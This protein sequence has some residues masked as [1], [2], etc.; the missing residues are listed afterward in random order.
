[1]G[2][3]GADPFDLLLY[4]QGQVGAP[5]DAAGATGADNLDTAQRAVVIGEPVPIVFG[6][7][8]GDVGGVLISPGATEARFEND[9]S[10]AVTATY[11][12]LL[13]EGEIDKVQVRDVFQRSCRVGTF[14]Q[15][16]DG[17][18][19][20]WTPG[21]FIVERIGYDKPE[22]PYYCGT[23]GSYAGV[24]TAFFTITVPDGFTQW[25]RQVHMFV[26]GGM[27][28]TRLLDD[29]TG[30]SNNVVDLVRWL[31]TNT[32]RL[33]SRLIDTDGMTAAAEFTDGMGLWFNGELREAQNLEDMMA[34][35]LRYFLLQ[36]TK[37]QGR[38]SLRPLLPVDGDNA[39]DLGP[40][41][42]VYLF[43]E[44][45]I[46][47]GSFEIS[48]IPLADR[49]PICAVMVWRQQPDDDIGLIR[50]T[51]V[52]YTATALEGPFEQH[53]LSQF[54]CSELHAVRAG[55]YILARRRWVTHTLRIR[56][57]PS[58]FNTTLQRGDVVQVK[59][60]RVASSAV[61]GEHNQLYEVD[62]IGKARSGE[63]S[64]DLVHFPVDGD[65]ASLVARDVM[66]ATASGVLFATGKADAITC[67]VNDPD[68]DSVPDEP[69]SPDYEA[70]DGLEGG[71]TGWGD[72]EAPAIPGDPGVP[73]GPPTTP[74][75][76]P[77]GDGIGGG[78]I[79][80]GEESPGGGTENPLDSKDK[81]KPIDLSG[82]PQDLQVGESLPQPLLDALKDKIANS[83]SGEEVGFD[84]S[85]W[86][87]QEY[88]VTFAFGT[89]F[90]SNSSGATGRDELLTYSR[91]RVTANS[92]FRA[93]Y[94]TPSVVFGATVGF[95]KRNGTGGL[96]PETL[97]VTGGIWATRGPGATDFSG[98]SDDV[99]IESATRTA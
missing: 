64:L 13:S 72:T 37:V 30:P 46:V 24:S 4:Q 7:R 45:R 41:S 95:T 49:R 53:D 17:R 73:S 55:A 93:G 20:T 96:D 76:W 75:G 11:H 39:V 29:V 33:P 60:A 21:N 63:I 32:S 54:C 8:V 80:G 9:T 87:T 6:R 69:E 48:Y 36:K 62:R 70:P 25:D 3:S 51:E 38:L 88:T 78:G 74:P 5:L 90:F 56:V 40:I 31:A 79:G 67:D 94:V 85:K 34:S 99:W 47:P 98:T 57:R 84:W 92:I 59:L 71:G 28:V 44:T 65:G 58:T 10:N 23:G 77:D 22:A 91:A 2:I 82:P 97:G 43:D 61:A 26:R 18:A 66:A 27:H 16:Y 50:T 83:A 68:D 15:T 19:G 14:G 12:L 35:T 89:F 81:Q 52:R 42:P 86:G 1:M